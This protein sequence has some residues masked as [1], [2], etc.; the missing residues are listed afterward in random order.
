[1]ELETLSKLYLELANVVPE[2]TKTKQIIALEETLAERPLPMR[3]EGVKILALVEVVSD[4][5]G[6]WFDDDGRAFSSESTFGWVPHGSIRE[7]NEN[8]R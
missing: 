1:M 3:S 2:G 5:H 6:G 4:A 7:E 8:G